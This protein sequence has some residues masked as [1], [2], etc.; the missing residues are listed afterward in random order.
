MSHGADVGTGV[1]LD[2]NVDDDG[3]VVDLG[4]GIG[5]HVGWGFAKNCL[6]AFRVEARKDAEMQQCRGRRWIL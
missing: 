3:D 6:S 2:I 4:G 1:I 5:S